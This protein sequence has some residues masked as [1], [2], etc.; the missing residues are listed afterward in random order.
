MEEI[1]QNLSGSI[2]VWGYIIL[3]FYSLGGGFI[4]LLAAGILSSGV[5]ESINSLNIY[6]CIFVAGT[7]NLIGSSVLFYISRYQKAEVMKYLKNH[8]RKI[9]LIS[10]WIK[11][12]D[13]IIIFIHKYVYGIKTIVPMVI[14]ISKYSNNKFMIYNFFASFIWA[15]LVGVLSYV[16]GDFIKK[17]YDSNPYIFPIFGVIILL[18]I[19]FLT[20]KIS[21]K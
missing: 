14:G 16:M 9:A 12:Y 17:T 4:A 13:F 11:K 2:G 5:I 6:L 1:L 15:I 3:F 8:K 20:S 18:A 10:I 19:F 7:A 21:K